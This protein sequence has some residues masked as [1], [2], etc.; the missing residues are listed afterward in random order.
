MLPYIR[1]KKS[2]S[3]GRNDNF[4]VKARKLSILPTL[5]DIFDIRQHFVHILYMTNSRNT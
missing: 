5:L 2:K 3:I 1:K 4:L